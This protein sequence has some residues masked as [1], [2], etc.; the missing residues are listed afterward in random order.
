MSARDLRRSGCHS[1]WPFSLLSCNGNSMSSTPSAVQSAPSTL[2]KSARLPTKN[3]LRL[4]RPIL[5]Q[6]PS[7]S[8]GSSSD[9]TSPQFSKLLGTVLGSPFLTTSELPGNELIDGTLSVVPRTH[10]VTRPTSPAPTIDYDTFSMI[11]PPSPTQSQLEMMDVFGSTTPNRSFL[12][13]PARPMSSSPGFVPLNGSL[14][15]TP[16]RTQFKSLLPRLWDALSSPARKGKG[17]YRRSGYE[18]DASGELQ[19]LDGEEGELI[20]DEACFI[21]VRAVTGVDIISLLP[22]ELALHL[23]SF[24][25]LPSILACLGVCRTWRS[26]ASDNSV[27][28]G[29]FEKQGGWN[30]NLQRAG[31]SGPFGVG[32]CKERERAVSLISNLDGSV[33]RLG[34]AIEEWG[35]RRLNSQSTYGHGAV[36]EWGRRR[37]TSQSTNISGAS[38][39]RLSA[40]S[41]RLA[42]WSPDPSVSG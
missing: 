9:P 7:S 24:L 2:S 26:L 33:A 11:N 31:R 5:T 25:E 10:T 1:W 21:D 3:S 8:S 30:I 28:R 27:W 16:P 18:Y 17:K 4:C 29:L 39:C 19:P 23:L 40:L 14:Y 35:R 13:S 42:T 37:L 6:F 36:E 22:P 38:A 41:S 34:H 32:K 12:S 15:Y 20:D